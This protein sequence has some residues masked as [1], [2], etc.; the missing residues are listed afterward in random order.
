MRCRI[1]DLETECKKLTMDMKLKEEQIRDLEGKCQ[2]RRNDIIMGNQQ[3]RIF[4]LLLAFFPQ[5]YILLALLLSLTNSAG[6]SGPAKAL[7]LWPHTPPPPFRRTDLF[8]QENGAENSRSCVGCQQKTN[9][10]I[11]GRISSVLA[12]SN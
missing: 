5:C 10:E 4:Y 7:P 12:T 8:F 9:T 6:D 2:V 3:S 11:K 1:R